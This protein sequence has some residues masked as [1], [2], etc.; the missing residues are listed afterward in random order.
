M[1]GMDFGRKMS[2]VSMINEGQLCSH[3]SCEAEKDDSP[4]PVTLR[5]SSRRILGRHMTNIS[6]QIGQKWKSVLPLVTTVTGKAST[7]I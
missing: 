5:K 7:P 2:L 6:E 1:L 3:T 4:L